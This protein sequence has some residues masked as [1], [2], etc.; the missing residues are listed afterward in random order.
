MTTEAIR[1]ELEPRVVLGKKVKQLR[2]AGIVPVHLYGPG[3]E[4]RP[5][6]CEQKTLLRTLARAGSTNPVN[7]SVQGEPGERLVFAREIQWGPVRGELLHVDFLAVSA[8]ERVTAQVPINLEGESPAA[9]DTGGA[10]AQALY[11]LDVEALPLEIPDEVVIDLSILVDTNSVIRAGELT[12]D[13]NVTVLTDPD[14]MVVRVEAGRLALTR[15][16]EPEAVDAVEPV[17]DALAPDESDEGEVE[18]EGEGEVEG[19]SEGEN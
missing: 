19:E 2:R 13:G 8:T 5:L 4:A 9:R 6:Q 18:G 14:S 12:L 16:D 17:A 15:T 3:M 1:L 10:V 11:Q 7:L